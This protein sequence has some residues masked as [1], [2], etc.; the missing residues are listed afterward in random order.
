MHHHDERGHRGMGRLRSVAASLFALMLLSLTV[1]TTSAAAAAVDLTVNVSTPKATYTVGDAAPYTVT[2]NNR[3]EADATAPATVTLDVPNAQGATWHEGITCTATGGA[4]CPT[5]FTLSGT[6]V[7]GVIPSLPKG[8]SVEFVATP[9]TFRVNAFMEGVHVVATVSPDSAD[10]E[11]TGVTNT[12]SVTPTFVPANYRYAVTSTG[13]AQAEGGTQISYDVVLHNTGEATNDLWTWTRVDAGAGNGSATTYPMPGLTITKAECVTA[14][15]GADCAKVVE[16]DVSRGVLQP[17][18]AVNGSGG[19]V[20]AVAQG[21]P[22]GGSVTIRLTVDVGV[23]TCSTST[24]PGT[25]T[26]TLSSQVNYSYPTG[27]FEANDPDSNNRS[28]VITN[29][30]ALPCVTG[31]L[32]VAS[33]TQPVSQSAG[34]LNAGAPYSYTVTYSNLSGAPAVNPGTDFLLVWTT[35]KDLGPVTPD[36]TPACVATG[37]GSICPTDFRVSGNAVVSSGGTLPAGASWQVTYTGITGGDSTLI[38]RP[39]RAMVTAEITPPG[40]FN[41][42]N[43]DP[44]SGFTVGQ[45]T[46][47]NNGRASDTQANVGVDCGITHD[48]QAQ[49]SGP[50]T[51][52]A[53]TVPLSGPAAPGQVLYYRTKFTS[54]APAPEFNLEHGSLMWSTA[55]YPRVFDAY[56]VHG[57]RGQTGDPAGI[58]FRDD[59]YWSGQPYPVTPFDTGVRCEAAGGAQCPTMISGGGSMGGGGT[60]IQRLG[61]WSANYPADGGAPMPAGGSLSYISAY[62]IPALD[63]T[64]GA[65]GCTPNARPVPL[66]MAFSVYGASDPASRDRNMANDLVRVTNSIAWPACTETL[67]VTKKALTPQMPLDR[68]AKYEVVVTNTSTHDLDLPRVIDAF[69]PVTSSTIECTATTGGAS[70]P[71]FAPQV[72]VR[73]KA[74]GT[75]DPLTTAV[76]LRPVT[77]DFTWGEPGASTM[78]AGSTVTF[79][80]TSTYD[81]GYAGTASNIVLF[82]GD[83]SST[84]GRWPTAAAQAL[85][86][87]PTG[88]QFAITKAV[89]PINPKPGQQVTFT[90]DVANLGQTTKNPF[91]ADYIDPILQPTNPAGFGALSCAPLP[92]DYFPGSVQDRLGSTPCPTFTSDAS[93]ITAT[94]PSFEGNS[95]F[96]L[97]YT[98]IAPMS[99]SST[100]NFASLVNDPTVVSSGDVLSQA[101][102][103]VQTALVTGT[104]WNDADGS[105]NGTLS[106]IRTNDEPGTDAG[107]LT[108]VLVD[109]ETGLVLNSAPVNPDGTYSLTAPINT[110]VYV[111]ITSAP[112]PA[113]GQP[114]G[115]TVVPTGWVNTSPM[116]YTVFDTGTQTTPERD[117]G[118]ERLP[119]TDDKTEPVRP[120]P[121]GSVQ[122]QVP[123]LTGSD[124]EDGIYA[125]AGD[126]FV[127]VTLPPSEQGV[128]YYDGSPVTAGQQ[129]VDYDPAKLTVDPAPGAVTVIFTVASVDAAGKVD[130]SPATVTIPFSVSDAA[131]LSG[132]VWHDVNGD[133]VRDGDEPGIGGVTVRL[134]G[135]TESGERVTRTVTTADNGSYVFDNL[136]PGT[137]TV[138]ETQPAGYADGADLLGIGA[139]TAGTLGNDVMR[140]IVLN[141]GDMAIHYDFGELTKRMVDPPKP[142]A[143]GRGLASTGAQGIGALLGLGLALVLI[144]GLLV[145][146]RRTHLTN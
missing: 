41:D 29:V 33:I 26:I 110:D 58:L 44:T 75:T 42:T 43:Y 19:S 24:P 95:G 34:G 91:F 97:T 129:I 137:Y 85:I 13:P 119:D 73:H 49:I 86:T 7:T 59:F 70:C 123:T 142:P 20:F 2:V 106:G 54:I 30:T 65:G 132:M 133:G 115:P 103:L 111:Q 136:A 81:K 98:A 107:G 12:A 5:A 113:F 140:G 10:T 77:Y 122:V 92:A 134:T 8:G 145:W 15:G 114:V 135:V 45:Q 99:A 14:S 102:L 57:F 96:R 93:G 16:S 120:N 40:D 125:G 64:A 87:A 27:N 61:G 138:R 69:T 126:T 37:A 68:V 84:Q 94:V 22:A 72:R 89:D 56:A 3:G 127:I 63:P 52:A 83:P 130:P 32:A 1:G 9:P 47:G 28:T 118:L 88:N 17:V 82:T 141:G 128:L 36:A 109:A 11:T 39:L 48:D 46:R 143:K 18:R 117:F 104:V 62:K 53:A 121:G 90:V 80:V 25:R 71:D 124:P 38:C 131:S 35:G 66:E 139:S 108:A 74:D 31:D 50:F 116:T 146:R 105:A 100:P 76:N 101:N 55:S 51:D 23:V 78:P 60:V 79:V 67:A 144:G 6:K 21:V 112:V 4:A